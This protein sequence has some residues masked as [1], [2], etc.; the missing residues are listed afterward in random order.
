MTM[1]VTKGEF[2]RRVKLLEQQVKA[3]NNN[4]LG[5]LQA[6]HDEFIKKIGEIDVSELPPDFISD[7]NNFKANFQRIDSAFDSDGEF[8]GSRIQPNTV[9]TAAL[10]VGQRSQQLSLTGVSF[11]VEPYNHD[12]NNY[13]ELSWSQGKMFHYGFGVGDT[14]KEY[15]ISDGNFSLGNNAYYIYAYIADL[16]STTTTAIIKVSTNQIKVDGEGKPSGFPSGYYIQLGYVSTELY[17][18]NSSGNIYYRK[19]D[20]TYGSTTINGRLIT[21][22]RIEGTTGTNPAYIDLDTGEIGGSFHLFTATAN[23]L[24]QDYVQSGMSG[25]R[26]YPSLWTGGKL[27]HAAQLAAFRDA[28]NSTNSV[29]PDNTYPSIITSDDQTE[30]EYKMHMYPYTITN[31]KRVYSSN[32]KLSFSAALKD[33]DATRP[34]YGVN[35]FQVPKAFIDY[36]GNAKFGK[37][38]LDQTGGFFLGNIQLTSNGEWINSLTSFIGTASIGDS[39]HHIYWNGSTFVPAPSSFLPLSGGTMTGN[40]VLKGGQYNREGALN[41]NNSDIIGVN[42]ILTADEATNFGEGLC[43]YRDAST[44]DCMSASNGTFYFGKNKAYQAAFA[45]DA[46]INCGSI[47]V[48]GDAFIGNTSSASHTISLQSSASQLRIFAYS[49]GASYIEAANSSFSANSS[50]GSLYLSGYN[51]N[52]LINIFLNASTTKCNGNFY[53]VG[54]VTALQS[55]SS[56]KRLKKNIKS[57]NAKQIIDKLNPLEFEWNKKANKYNSNLE[58]NKKNYGLIAQDSDGIID[59]LVFDLPDGKGYKGV[60]YEKLIPILLQA[61]K[62]QQK[63]IDELKRKIK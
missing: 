38:Y 13:G 50:N 14:P 34:V 47:N 35:K 46:T 51:N 5:K 7:Y 61:V 2:D 59:N 17:A 3:Y 29:P 9:S 4:L 48:N 25:V 45:G 40:L 23:N 10:T 26:D 56:D 32:N 15:T 49:D 28:Y 22:G 11:G 44:W 18:P 39:T 58:L 57:F 24:I 6:E 63:E 31:G 20:T 43:F 36:N 33:A 42:S 53:A 30:Y 55:S 27:E 52:N 21:T 12:N 8:D 54:A 60:R 16:E 19:V 1:Q 37:M 62:E 41:C